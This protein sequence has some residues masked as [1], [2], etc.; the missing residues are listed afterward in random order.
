M[1][2]GFDV[3]LFR[4]LKIWKSLIFVLFVCQLAVTF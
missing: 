3:V 2:Y 4:L 1:T